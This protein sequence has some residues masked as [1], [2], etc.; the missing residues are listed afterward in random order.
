ML[1]LG[2]RKGQSIYIYPESGVDP[3]TP[4][5]EVFKDGPM[6]ITFYG[7]QSPTNARLGIDAPRELAIVRDDVI[8]GP[9]QD[10]EPAS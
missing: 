6:V 10:A 7:N 4:I 2:R 9:D 3:S 5:G 1:I 8:Q